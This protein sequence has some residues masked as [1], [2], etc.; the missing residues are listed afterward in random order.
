M[1]RVYKPAE[2]NCSG[3][4]DYNARRYADIREVYERQLK[5]FEK[6]GLGGVTEFGTVVTVQLCRITEQRLR[7]IRKLTYRF[8]SKAQEKATESGFSGGFQLKL[9]REEEKAMQ[10][11]LDEAVEMKEVA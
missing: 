4:G 2:Q 8:N 3:L 9:D 11:L 7:Q 6:L 5:K 10:K 1:A